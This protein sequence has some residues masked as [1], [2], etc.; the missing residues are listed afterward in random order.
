MLSKLQMNGLPGLNINL[1]TE[2]CGE[3]GV[4]VRDLK[5]VQFK[6]PYRGFKI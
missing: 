3:L 6:G 5:K 2:P 1:G 4:A